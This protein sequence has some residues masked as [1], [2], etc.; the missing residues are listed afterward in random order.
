[1]RACMAHVAAR[2]VVARPR[3]A[4]A[5]AAP[6][7]RRC[8]WSGLQPGRSDRRSGI[9]VAAGGSEISDEDAAGVVEEVEEVAEP[10]SRLVVDG[11]T[12]SESAP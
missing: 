11:N 12:T 8:S 1:M 2:I 9:P 5:A 7:G 6:A 10:T 4:A 3:G